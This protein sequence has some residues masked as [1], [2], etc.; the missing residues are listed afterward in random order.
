MMMIF[1]MSHQNSTND[2]FGFNNKNKYKYLRKFGKDT[3]YN[4]QNINPDTTKHH[5]K[6]LWQSIFYLPYN[7][8]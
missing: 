2:Y 3:N 8:P 4:N 5:E 7:I 1:L 6:Y